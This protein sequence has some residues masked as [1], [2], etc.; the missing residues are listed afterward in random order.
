MGEHHV[1]LHRLSG[2]A[3]RAAWMWAPRD[4]P[5]P[6]FPNFP[7]LWPKVVILMAGGR[8]L[9]TWTHRAAPTSCPP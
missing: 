8:Q 1:T 6:P 9:S 2:E 3:Q 5:L 4:A 7:C